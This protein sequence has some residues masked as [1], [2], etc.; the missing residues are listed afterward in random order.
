MATSFAIAASLVPVPWDEAM[1]FPEAVPG[2]GVVTIVAGVGRFPAVQAAGEGVGQHVNASISERGYAYAT[3]LLSIV[4]VPQVYD[5]YSVAS[6]TDVVERARTLRALALREL[7]Q[8]SSG[9]GLLELPRS[10][11]RYPWT[12][13]SLNIFGVFVWHRLQEVCFASSSSAKPPHAGSTAKAATRLYLCVLPF[14]PSFRSGTPGAVGCR[15][16][17]NHGD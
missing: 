16:V 8:H 13:L 10:R 1:R 12:S 7:V 9:A 14:F 4:L 5:G 6:G 15:V 17:G 11:M 2:S 3:D